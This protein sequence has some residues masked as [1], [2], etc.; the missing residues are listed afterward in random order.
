MTEQPTIEWTELAHRANDGVDVMLVW[1]HGDGVDEVVVSVY[2]ALEGSYF[3]ITVDPGLALDAYHHPFA[4]RDS[5]A[6][7]DSR[8][9]AVLS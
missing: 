3:E 5:R 4:Y 8:R 1:V 6:V 2:D 9:D 7:K